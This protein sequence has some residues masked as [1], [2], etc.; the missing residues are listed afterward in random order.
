MNIFITGGT[1]FIGSNL[2]N[3]F[4]KKNNKII[5]NYN[6]K[7]IPFKKI[8]N[9]RISLLKKINLN[10]KIDA[11]IHCASKTPIN[12]SSNT[13]IFKENLKMMNN[14]IYLAKKKKIKK[15]I[16]L[17]S[18]SVYGKIN[19]KVLK[20]DYKPNNPN[21]YGIS[22]LICEQALNEL[23]KYNISFISIRLPIVVGEDS[24]SNFISKITHKIID[25]KEIK[26]R[27][28]NSYFNNIVFVEDLAKYIKDFLNNKKE[29]PKIVNLGS[30]YKMKINNVVNFLYKKLDKEK[31]IHWIRSGPKSF[32]IDFSIAKKN[33]FKP[34]SVKLCLEK[35][36]DIFLKKTKD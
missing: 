33:G 12:C 32:L 29:N 36:T 11:I 16:F 14:L 1:G 6:K 23:S 31:N 5:C 9:L 20:E 28:K 34:R 18:V 35:Y 15:F 10:S 3:Y 2:V 4:N 19:I 30:N 17:S 22:K 24:H 27:N 13:Q 26:A 8:K 7:K 21:K 25:N